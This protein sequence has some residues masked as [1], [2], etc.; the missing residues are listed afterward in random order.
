MGVTDFLQRLRLRIWVAL[1]RIVTMR[2]QGPLLH[3]PDDVKRKNLQIPSRDAGRSIDAWLYYPDDYSPDSPASS[4]PVLINWHGSGYVNYALSLDHE[5]CHYLAQTNG[6]LVLDVDYRK[7]PENPYPAP[8]EDVEDVL[9]WVSEQQAT[10]DVSRIALSGFSSG[11]VLA[12][13]AAS[14]L[15]ANYPK[16]DIKAV[17]TIYSGSDLA[18]E[19]KAKTVPRPVKPIPAWVLDIFFDSY[20][21][22]HVSRK[23][24]R[25]SPLYADPNLFPERVIMVTC[26]GDILKPEMD[27]L[28]DKLE[29]AGRQVQA[30]CLEDMPHGFDKGCKPNTPEWENK[31]YTYKL[32]ADSLKEALT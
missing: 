1:F 3:P 32:V 20:L 23:D 18:T 8:I 16:L 2:V 29:G 12:Q 30:V 15:R 26:S 24:P 31:E 7:A 27:V 14:S 25:V 17:V 28:A 11:G 22:P 6:M 9:A 4:L 10:M 19:S 21:P 5:Y 13:A